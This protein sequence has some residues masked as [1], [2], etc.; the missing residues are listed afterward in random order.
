MKITLDTNILLSYPEIIEKYEEIILPIA[1]IEELDGLKKDNGVTG[2]NARQAIRKLEEAKNI[3]YIIKDE[4]TMPNGWNKDKR[5]NAIIL[6]AKENGCKLLSNDLNV[7][8]K[9]N[10]IG[11]ECEGVNDKRKELDYKGYKEVFLDTTIE[12]DNNLLSHLYSSRENNLFDLYVNQYILLKDKSKPIYSEDNFNEIVDYEII[13]KFRWNGE[14]LV[15]LKLPNSKVVKPLNVLQMFALDLLNNR[16]IPIKIIVGNYG[17]GKTMLSI[18]VGL[19]QVNDKGYYSKIMLVRNP[20]GSGEE[21]GFLPGSKQEKIQDF[22][23]PIEQN[24]EGGEFQLQSMLQQGKLEMEIPFYMKGMTLDNTYTIIDE[25][26][27]LD[28]K[29]LKL[30]GTRI[31]KESCIVF[32]GDYKQAESKYIRNNGLLTM[33]DKLKDN[34]L[35]G[36]V[37]LNEDV[38]S[39]ASKVFA[40]L[41]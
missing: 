36:I 6:C 1:V 22:F 17:S 16:D 3:Q 12:E 19:N 31:G 41:E 8:I 37:V 29:T 24:L 14:Q 30:I 21:I 40:Y 7:R 23:K 13:D 2:Y 34:P 35:V 28:L 4:Y 26:E 38:R 39:S 25:A 11:V 32:S 9:A 20:I 10:A 15:D 33:I 27:D 5:D 18:R